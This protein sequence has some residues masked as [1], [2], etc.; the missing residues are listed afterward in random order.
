MR[1]WVRLLRQVLEAMGATD[2]L[3]YPRGRQP[4]P[5]SPSPLPKPKPGPSVEVG[6][7]RRLSEDV[8]RMRAVIREVAG[9]STPKPDALIKK[10]QISKQRGRAALR[11]LEE[12]EGYRGFARAKP[13]RYWRR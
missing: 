12:H 2:L 4:T 5:T 3:P 11:W 9:D 7:D 13:D 1:E 10:A 8:Q 6:L